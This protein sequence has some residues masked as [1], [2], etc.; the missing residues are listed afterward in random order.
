[1]R[2][3]FTYM[4]TTPGK[5]LLFMGCEFG[6]F[7][8]WDYENQL[9]WFMTDF[10]NHDRLQYFTAELNHFY[11]THPELWERDFSWDG[12]RWINADDAAA[13]VVTYRRFDS[14]GGELIIGVNF[15]GSTHK[16]YTVKTGDKKDCDILFSTDEERFGGTGTLTPRRIKNIDGALH[17]DFPAL[18]AFIARPVKTGK[19]KKQSRTKG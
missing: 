1:M 3:F 8:E 2:S 13:N 15:A 19:N 10:E 18:S 7:R 9:E 4:M 12:Y 16:N 5:K 14:R 17:I 6:Q 11:L